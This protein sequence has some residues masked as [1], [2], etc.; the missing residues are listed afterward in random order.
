MKKKGFKVTGR[1]LM[2]A[3]AVAVPSL[4]AGSMTAEACTSYYAGKKTT[5]DGSIMFGRTEDIGGSHSKIFKVYPA[6]VH[7]QGEMYKD[8]TKFTM[9][10][11]AKTYRYTACED[12]PGYGGELFGEVGTNE[13]GV[14][15]SATESASP[16]SAVKEADPFT[17]NGI[18][19]ASMVSA[20]L[21]CI[22]TA[23]EGVDFLADILDTYG[24][25]EGN[26][27]MFADKNEC[28][29][30]EIL[31]GH[32]YAAI[33]MP[34]DKAG[35]MPNC[36]MIGNIDVTD[37]E[38]VVASEELISTAEKA[39]V[40]VRDGENTNTINIRKSYGGTMRESNTNRI[41][42][43]Q[44]ILNPDLK[45]TITPEDAD[46]EMFVTPKE[47]VSIQ[48]L[49]K[50]A[51]TQYE[52]EE[53]EGI[54]SEK[55][56]TVIGTP[57]SC[58]CHV[59]QIRPEMPT[60]LAT[61]E[62]LSMGSADLSP[63][64]PFYSAALTDTHPAYKAGDIVYN[65]ASAY[66]AFRSLAS[67]SMA[68]ASRDLAANNIKQYW[69]NYVNSLVEAQASVD[70]KMLSL[71]KTNPAAVSAKADNLGMA[72]ADE[73]IAAAK[74]MYRE[75]AAR[76]AA[77]NGQIVA[78]RKEPTFIPSMLKAEKYSGYSYDMVYKAP[79]NFT[80]TKEEVDALKSQAA[81]AN[82]NF[83]DAQAKLADA[84]KELADAQKE[85]AAARKELEQLKKPQVKISTNKTK[86]TVKKGKK[87]KIKASVENASGKKIIFKSENKKVAKVSAKGVV[88][89]VK[90]GKAVISI[91]CNGVTKEVKVVVK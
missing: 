60:E 42:G 52:S 48:T 34:E 33:K 39:N 16:V 24:A 50:I 63:F 61:V 59:L 15:M 20:V 71:Y 49:Y 84:Q 5:V 83:A 55:V 35:I 87:V 28:W 79:E 72:V 66:W 10:L 91:K 21:P 9:P 69:T 80:A 40:L 26:T 58:E 81:Q 53:F 22:K 89:G 31:S 88:T 44:L 18:T 56:L 14:S 64:L 76:L 74:Q 47:K 2:L 77:G 11:P 36:F 7:A 6:A 68:A 57:R 43:G 62:W 82:K 1:G 51:G 38:N 32:Q 67:M 13:L 86:Y 27:L 23:R 25:G 70:E 90:K 54:E 46:Y 75:L 29:Y 30:F 73:A 85:L 8:V 12:D 78:T 41:W 3:M 4:A 45:E 37:T 17:D 65:D 19:E